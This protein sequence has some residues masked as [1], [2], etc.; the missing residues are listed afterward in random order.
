[1]RGSGCRG[2]RSSSTVGHDVCRQHSDVLDAGAAEE[3]EVLL[4]L[5]LARPSAGSLI[6]N[7]IRPC[8]PV[9]TFDISAEYSVEMSS[10]EKWS[11]S[12]IP[13]VFSKYS[14]PVVHAAELDVADHV[15]NRA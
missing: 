14:T 7:L 12:V 15:V 5:A 6:G 11:I 4:D 1:M 10:S 9:I 2:E 13:I 8:P 3:V